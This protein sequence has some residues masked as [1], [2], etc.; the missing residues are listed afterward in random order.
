MANRIS[1]LFDKAAQW[2][3]RQCGRAEDQTDLR[4]LNLACQRLPED[5]KDAL[6]LIAVEE[7]SYEEVS[8]TSGCAIGTLKSRVHRARQQLRSAMSGEARAAA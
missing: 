4:E 2:A 3:A 1:T 7:R 8:D 5:Q 6:R